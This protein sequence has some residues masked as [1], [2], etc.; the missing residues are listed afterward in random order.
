M[1]REPVS[2]LFRKL[3]RFAQGERKVI[4]GYLLLFVV[5]NLFLLVGPLVFGAVVREIQQEGVKSSNLV[6]LIALLSLLFFKEIGFWLFHG[7]ARVIERLV[8]FNI[9]LR[10]RR[11]LL[12]GVLDLDLAWHHEN[13]S[14]NVIEQIRRAADN[15][16]EFGENVFQAIQLSVRVCSTAIVLWFFSEPTAVLVF[17]MVVLSLYVFSRFDLRLLPLIEGLNEYS[18]KASA[19]AFDALANITTVKILH[20]EKPVSEGVMARYGN[21]YSLF[22]RSAIVNEYKWAAGLLLFM[23]VNFLPL[24][25]YIALKVYQGQSVDA[26][27][28]STLYLFIAEL[29]FVYATFGAYYEQV[30]RFRNGV[31]NAESLEGLIANRKSSPR[32]LLEVS[33]R[34]ALSKLTFAYDEQKSRGFAFAEIDFSM[35]AG[36]KIAIIGESGSGKTTFLKVI[37]G[38]YPQAQCSLQIDAQ[39]LEKVTLSSVDL[40]TMLV[41][42]DPEI[43]SA[44]I[45]E[46]LSLGIAYSEE[47]LLRAVEIARFST[48]LAS[49]PQGLDSV[50]NEK[51]VNLSGGQRQRLALARAILFANDKKIL[52]LDESTSSVD[53]ENEMA[54]YH[55]IFAHFSDKTVVASIHK[56][57]LLRYFE[58]IVI[59]DKGKIIDEGTFAELLAGNASFRNS[60]RAFSQ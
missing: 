20:I 13:D 7:P 40:A 50:I 58:R 6:Y 53:S 25:F 55:S 44:S 39:L 46:N 18:N 1:S 32:R 12:E 10:Y 35:R 47:D 2:Y 30:S 38:L 5:A 27:T 11:Y 8:A 4:Y 9:A 34:L 51:G 36:E 28:I 48:V 14:G 54:I 52:L 43:F 24:G 15:L 22:K 57:N 26:G 17:V 16:G 19:G 33:S 21:A 23:V 45:R 42:Q 3:W 37:H 41:P 29:L 59:F 60:W 49:L 56:L 31:I